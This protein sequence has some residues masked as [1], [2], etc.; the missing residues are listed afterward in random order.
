MAEKEKAQKPKGEIND[1]RR[2]IIGNDRK[3]SK[4]PTIDQS[5]PM[6]AVKP[7]KKK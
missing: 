6:P 1:G 5:I 3:N 2:E 4:L 7:P